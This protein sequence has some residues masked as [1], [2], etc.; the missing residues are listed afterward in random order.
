LDR[1]IEAFL[2]VAFALAIIYVGKQMLTQGQ[3]KLLG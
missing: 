1:K 3:Q 2:Q